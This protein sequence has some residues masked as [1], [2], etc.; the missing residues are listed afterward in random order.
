MADKPAGLGPRGSALWDELEAGC[1][2][3]GGGADLA[4]EACR[5]ADRLDKLHAALSSDRRVWGSLRLPGNGNGDTYTLIVTGA[6][7]EARQQALALR[8]IVAG[9]PRKGDNDD[10]GVNNFLAGIGVR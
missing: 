8:M 5:I 1:D 3:D 10:S 9:L 7:A 6:L 4:L 2:L